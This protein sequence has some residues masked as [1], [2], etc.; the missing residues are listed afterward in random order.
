MI[1][2]KGILLPYAFNGHIFHLSIFILSILFTISNPILP[3]VTSAQT[4]ISA[5]IVTPPMH[6]VSSTGD[7]WMNTWADDDHIYTGWGDGTGPGNTEPS[8]DCG[9]GV[10]KEAVPYFFIEPDPQDFVRCKFVPDGQP[11]SI[12][13]DKPSSL[14]FLD[15]R[16]YM[17]GHTPLGDAEYGYIAFSGDYGQS[18]TEVVG[19]PWTR[20]SNSPFRCLTF[21]QMGRSYEL[22]EDGYVYGLGIGTEWAW[23]SQEIFLARVPKDS[24]V[25]YDCYRYYTG[26]NDQTP[27]WSDLQS[28]AVPLKHVGTHQM[29]SAMYH[30][31]IERYLCLTIDGLF[32]APNPWGPWTEVARILQSGDDPEWKDPESSYMPGILSKGAG[33]DFVYFTLA[34][35]GDT[36]RYQLHV[37]KIAFELQSEIEAQAS[38]SHT[39]GRAPLAVQF[40]GIG[41]A[42]GATIVS[43]R[44]YF[45]DGVVSSEQHPSHVYTTPS[46]GKYRAM[47]T[48]S[49]DR[50]RRGFDIVEITIPHCELTYREPENPDSSEAGLYVRYY[51]LPS[52]GGGTVPDFSSMTEYRI[53]IVPDI[54]YYLPRGGVR[55]GVEFATSGRTDSV[56]A[57]FT[58]YIDAPEDGIYTFYVLSDDASDVYV[59]HEKVVEN[60]GEHWCHM[61]ERAG[62][63]GLKAGKHALSIGY[64]EISGLCG[65]R[66]YWEGPGFERELVLPA[67]LGHTA[68]LTKG[69]VDGNGTI[70][71]IDVL[72][73]VNII[74]GLLEPT[75]TQ[76]WTADYNADGIVDILD[77]IG[78]IQILLYQ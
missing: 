12:R 42:P 50:G 54:D 41:I 9:I 72:S 18:W 43:Y 13:D 44:W 36:I 24:I 29:C 74:L 64:T 4:I 37:G 61:R 69:D 71:V 16:V 78:I 7:L 60:Y 11:T 27:I 22:N 33:A 47:L 76:Y 57:L 34:G 6:P 46:Y 52:G 5:E 1:Y 17:A 30:Q 53:D 10:L 68:V 56:A 20:A 38:A 45:G 39:L 2:T 75:P 14:L 15:G 73:A 25:N 49:D 48:V 77:V 62:Q 3:E 40:Q 8:T 35:Q 23:W 65:L 55:R 59:G 66:L 51:N 21:I 31:G 70:N 32:E 63:I 19:S 28:K 58:G 26:L 67:S